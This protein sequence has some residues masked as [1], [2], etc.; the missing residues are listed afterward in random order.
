V[1]C[2]RRRRL[3]CSKSGDQQEQ[4]GEMARTQTHRYL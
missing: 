3:R 1:P 4:A 2:A